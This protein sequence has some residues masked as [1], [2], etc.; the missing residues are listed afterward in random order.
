MTESTE[1]WSNWLDEHGAALVMLARRWA[2]SRSDAEDIVQ[3]AF[4]RFWR[5]RGDVAEPIGYLYACVKH[6]AID[7]LRGRER[8]QRREL[9]NARP[10]ADAMF[11]APIEMDERRL[12]IEGALRSLPENQA[13]VLVMKIW[14]GLSFPQ[15]A[16]ALEI[17]PNTA[18]SRYRYALSKMREQ[19][20]AEPIL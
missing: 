9:A 19:L 1:S 11:V 4:V 16:V 14:G 18:A 3:E 8:R 20:A 15:I 2:A 5:T 12:A 17:S 7:W 10:E 6:C 13:E